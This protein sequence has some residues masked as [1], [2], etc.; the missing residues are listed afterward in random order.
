MSARLAQISPQTQRASVCSVP[1]V[2]PDALQAPL[3]FTVYFI[4]RR[5]G[6]SEQLCDHPKATQAGSP[7][8]V[9]LNPDSLAHFSFRVLISVSSNPASSL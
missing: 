7:P 9:P 2:G 8:P 6:G 3:S 5:T 4:C 1:D